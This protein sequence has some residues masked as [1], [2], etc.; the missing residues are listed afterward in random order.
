MHSN[1][2][3]DITFSVIGRTIKN[4]TSKVQNIVTK[5]YKPI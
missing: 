2:D 1:R 3:F 4:K 5:H